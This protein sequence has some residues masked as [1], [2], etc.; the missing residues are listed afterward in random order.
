MNARSTLVSPLGELEPKTRGSE[1]PEDISQYLKEIRKCPVLTALE[2]RCLGRKIESGAYLE[3]IS[4]VEHNPVEVAETL[5]NTLARYQDVADALAGVLGL[6]EK[7][8]LS[9]ITGGERFRKFLDGVSEEETKGKIAM[10][11]EEP[12]EDVGAALLELS[13]SSRLLPREAVE[14]I[15]PDARLQE[16][17]NRIER[18]EIRQALGAAE[19]KIAVFYQEAREEGERAK[20]RLTECNLRWVA[21]IANQYRYKSAL[22]LKDLI[23]EGNL[24]LM[25]AVEGFDYRKGFKFSTY[26]TWWIRQTITRA[27][28]DQSRTI[29]IPVHITERRQN[30]VKAQDLL[31]G[32][33]GRL[34]T[35]EELAEATEMSANAVQEL[36]QNTRRVVSLDEPIGREETDAVGSFIADPGQ[37]PEDEASH[38]LLRT[39]LEELIGT[40]NL[41]EQRI[42]R[43]RFGWENGRSWTLDEVGAEFGVTRERIRQ[44][45]AG[46]IRKLQANPKVE[47]LRGSLE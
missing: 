28:A 40:L 26:A 9:Q 13:M 38:L 34:P 31:T 18:E 3:R 8:T 46:A 43:L 27:M 33:L 11:L 39:G 25:R 29:R 5:V 37:G 42:L 47:W 6:P 32:E 17:E 35:N 45:Q 23:Q 14:A 21:T 30:L 44:V 41:R 20:K 4:G 24:G 16:L 7:V 10:A 36:W 1:D 22:T 15:G 2:E 12:L 19:A